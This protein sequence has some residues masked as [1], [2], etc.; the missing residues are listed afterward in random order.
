MASRQEAVV[1]QIP[2]LRRYARA[3]TGDDG[4]TDDL[5]QD[6][7]ERALARIDQWRDGDNPCKWMLSILHNLHVDGLRR[8]SRRPLHVGLENVGLSSTAAA[9]DSASGC[10]V[11]RALQL[12]SVG[13]RQVLLL[14]GV[15][16]L[17]YAETADVLGIPIGTVMSRL[18]RGRDRLRLLMAC[19]NGISDERAAVRRPRLAAGRLPPRSTPAWRAPRQRQ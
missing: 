6:T 5:I 10:D 7:L 19:E 4:E 13:Q 2:R 17:T 9:A 16:G 18:A 1:R 14:V 8:R 11:D 15:E 3:L 12:M